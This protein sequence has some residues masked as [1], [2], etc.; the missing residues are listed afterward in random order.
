MLKA[1]LVLTFVALLAALPPTERVGT[2]S[3]EGLLQS[4]GSRTKSARDTVTFPGRPIDAVLSTDGTMLYVKDSGAVRTISVVARKEVA[5][6]PL[7]GGASQLGLAISESL[8]LLVM[9]NAKDSLMLYSLAD[10]QKPVFVR[11][12]KTSGQYPCGVA[13]SRDGRTAYVCLSM[14]N[15]LDIVDLSEGAVSRTIPVGIAPVSVCLDPGGDL[16]YVACQG[17]NSPGPADLFASSAGTSIRVDS[18]GI[19]LGGCLYALDLKG[20]S[21][22]KR[23]DV[24]RQPSGMVVDPVTRRLYLS[25]TNE[26]R[27]A[28]FDLKGLGRRGE[29][30]MTTPSG[31]W[32][33]MPTGLAIQG[34]HL[35]V[36]LSGTS[37]L[38]S[39][40]LA[41]DRLK[42]EGTLR[43]DWFPVAVA[44][45]DNLIAVV[46]TK[47]QG[48]RT[49]TR[50]MDQGH[51]V[52]DFMGSISLITRPNFVKPMASA[53]QVEKASAEPTPVPARVGDPSQIKHIF[54]VI[55]ENRTYDQVFGDITSGDGDPNL[56]VFGEKVTPNQHSLAREF[57]LLDNYYCNGVL[58][59]D[60]HSWETEGNVTPY[61]ERAFGGFSR[62]YTFGD[63]PLT[64]SSTGFVWDAL[65]DKGVSFRN[66][67]EFDY[68]E[69][70]DKL[71]GKQI[72]EAYFAGKP[73][74]FSQNIGVAR[75]AKL[76]CRDYPGWNMAIPDQLRMDR[77]LTE[78]RQ[79]EKDGKLPQFVIVYLPQD[80]TGGPATPNQH[81]ADNDLAV[82]RLVEAVTHSRYWP[83]SAIFINE[84]DPSA[85][86]DHVDG[87]RSTCLVVSP[88]SRKRGT[89][90]RFYNQTSVL[91][92]ILAIFGCPPLNNAIAR[93]PLMSE[94]F[95]Q[96]LDLTP[97]RLRPNQ[98]PLDGQPGQTDKAVLA[99]NLSHHE[100]DSVAGMD[101]LNRAIWREARK[102]APYP[103]RFTG[104]HGLG[105]KRRGLKLVPAD[106]D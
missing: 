9:S 88:Y 43:T 48:S 64:Y 62:S 74:Q 47:G 34:H 17:G 87:H 105:L 31:L 70:R 79:F 6:T 103:K 98:I 96:R 106:P 14:S 76:S 3:A 63:D 18:R 101:I 32:G 29:V 19:A 54:Y 24:G 49:A 65:L 38:A 100:V 80:H 10:P 53:T 39:I 1:A 46:N 59:A 36:T 84:D 33:S 57:G 40:E 56:C 22:P 94:C 68:A 99:L 45:R 97:Y 21:K 78:F 12:I 102:S 50:P 2:E 55:K 71:A 72:M 20:K 28:E 60:G 83:D 27:I 15:C 41:G 91:R 44:A 86:F 92:T 90:S 95:D 51:L 4:D 42:V 75:I 5:S 37:E 13:V 8:H 30:K 81:V 26:D 67:G 25:E 11:Q 69:S 7:P 85:G 104:A 58:S 82:G 93:A 35:F 52:A 61:L 66:Y 73:L 23:V 89:V 77:F 16:V